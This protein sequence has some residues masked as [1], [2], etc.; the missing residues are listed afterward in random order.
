MRA[1]WYGPF[2][3]V[4]VNNGDDGTPASYRLQLPSQWRV[5]DTFAAHKIIRWNPAVHWPCHKAEQT[6]PPLELVGGKEEHVV[7]R[8]VRH[9]WATNQGK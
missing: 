3:I 5:H 6:V 9:I 1:Q 2:T 7:K 4:E 8:I